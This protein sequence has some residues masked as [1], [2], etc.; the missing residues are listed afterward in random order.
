[1]KRMFWAML[2]AVMLSAC[3]S[4]REYINYRGMSMGMSARQLAD[5]LQKQ[6]LALDT[7]KYEDRYVLADTLANNFTVAIYHQNDTI[8][9]ILENYIATYNDS[10]SQLWQKIR[11][12]LAEEF[13]WPN[14]GKH[15]DLHKEATFQNK[16]G[17][18]IVTLLNTY[19]P[20]LTVRYSTAQTP[21]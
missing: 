12:E 6:G 17:T 2:A 8:G 1:M 13:G 7:T 4:E 9:D 14:M 19:S 3:S 10:T 18:V 21:E 20:T 11:D 5:S 16:K 15:G